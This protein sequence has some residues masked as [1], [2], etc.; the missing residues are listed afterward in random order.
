MD[1]ALIFHFWSGES[2]NKAYWGP[3]QIP[4]TNKGADYFSIF[5]NATEN[6]APSE[7]RSY[8]FH[9]YTVAKTFQDGSLAQTDRRKG[10]NV[11]PPYYNE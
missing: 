11:L 6:A 5:H 9:Y 10:K 3:L 4:T 7:T 8:V 1:L 2:K